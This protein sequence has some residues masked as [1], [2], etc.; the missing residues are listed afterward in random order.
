MSCY[1]YTLDIDLVDLDTMHTLDTLEL[2][3]LLRRDEHDRMTI[4]TRSTSTTDT[5]DICLWIVWDMVVDYESDIVEIE[6]SRCDIRTD[7]YS[8]FTSLERLDSSYSISLHHISVD[9]GC[10]ESITVEVSLEFLC[11]MFSSGEYDH[12]MLWKSLK[13]TLEK[14]VLVTRSHTHEYMI[15]RIDGRRL[16]EDE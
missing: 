2:A 1:N 6:S 13:S 5:V 15:D 8:D 3:S 14:W 10:R 7:E 16:R 4:G 11:L 9:I 12:L